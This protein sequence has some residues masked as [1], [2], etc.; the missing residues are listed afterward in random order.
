MKYKI[1]LTKRSVAIVSITIV[2]IA[3]LTL[4]SWIRNSAIPWFVNQKV[5]KQVDDVY[6]STFRDINQQLGNDGIQFNPDKN[7]PTCWTANYHYLRVSIWCPRLRSIANDYSTPQALINNWPVFVQS[8]DLGD[9]QPSWIYDASFNPRVVDPHDL[10]R[11][12][13][14]ST[15]SIRFIR[16]IGKVQCSMFFSAS[17]AQGGFKS[18]IYIEESCHR[19]VNI[20]GG[21]DC[22]KQDCKA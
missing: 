1:K 10:F 14:T 9:R 20:F 22:T 2:L 7:G 6:A 16:Q 12:N 17:S 15:N 18:G 8:L 4:P 21:W 5:G 11:F 13:G 3:C 19:T